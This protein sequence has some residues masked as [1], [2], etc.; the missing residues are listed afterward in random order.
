MNLKEEKDEG[1]LD[2]EGFLADPDGFVEMMTEIIFDGEEGLYE[3]VIAK[4]SQR[5]E[6]MAHARE[7]LE[8]GETLKD[9][10]DVLGALLKRYITEDPSLLNEFSGLFEVESDPD[11]PVYDPTKRRSG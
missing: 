1:N 8:E 2:L 10:P 11:E 6:V 4:L 3:D 9:K 7:L 5:K